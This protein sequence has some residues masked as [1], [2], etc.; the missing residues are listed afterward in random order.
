[1][2]SWFANGTDSYPL[3]HNENKQLAI[4]SRFGVVLF[5]SSLT[6]EQASTQ[7]WTCLAELQVSVRHCVTAAVT[8][9]RLSRLEFAGTNCL[10]HSELLAIKSPF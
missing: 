8:F 2:I 5:V 3:V 1:M 9:W 10:T 6:S 4:P 7:V